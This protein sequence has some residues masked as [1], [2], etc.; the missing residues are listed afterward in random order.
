MLFRLKKSNAF[1]KVMTDREIINKKLYIRALPS[2]PFLMFKKHLYAVMTIKKLNINE[3]L[4]GNQVGG[5][6][7]CQI[8]L[9]GLTWKLIKRMLKTPADRTFSFKLIL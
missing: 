1:L 2:I 5:L 7:Q 8:R 9:N 6:K 3:Y 4:Y